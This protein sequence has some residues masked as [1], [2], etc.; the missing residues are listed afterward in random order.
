[1]EN[2]ENEKL[3]DDVTPP[4]EN[5]TELVENEMVPFRGDQ[6]EITIEVASKLAEYEKALN[7][8]MNF[9]VKRTYAGDWVSHDKKGT[10]ETERSVNM[11]GAAA[12]RIARDLGIQESNRTQPVKRMNEKYPGHYIYECEGD[13]TFRGRSVHAVGMASTRNPFHYKSW[14]GEKKPEDIREEYLVREAWRDCTK[15]GVKQLFGLRKIPLMK[16]K[17][18]G[19]DITKVKYVDFEVG[20]GSATK[21]AE[22]K[23]EAVKSTVSVTLKTHE[24]KMW[25]DKPRQDFTDDKG[26]FYSFWRPVEHEDIQRLLTAI[27]NEE[28]VV[29]EV[30]SNGKY[31]SIDKVIEVV[32]R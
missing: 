30:R 2:K 4:T 5:D 19:Y 24:S 13:F 25:Q 16:L 9:I 29:M 18:L 22:A 21:K 31:N 6:M 1:M 14:G 3:P 23:T 7:M 10:P 26:V 28:L 17:E 27:T 11:I 20:E 32:P 8:I 12:E 15:Q